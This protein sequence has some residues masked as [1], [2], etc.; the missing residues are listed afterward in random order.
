MKLP[1]YRQELVAHGVSGEPMWKAL[2]LFI[3]QGAGGE[4][5]V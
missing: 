2:C 5:V 3:D 4:Y 1:V